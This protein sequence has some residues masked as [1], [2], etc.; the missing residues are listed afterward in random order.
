MS[1]RTDNPYNQDW[2]LLKFNNT[3]SSL[4]VIRLS[5]TGTSTQTDTNTSTQIFGATAVGST[6]TSSTFSNAQIYIPNYTSSNYKTWATESVNE[7]NATGSEAITNMFG[8][9]WSNTAAITRVTLTPYS[10]GTIQQYSTAYLYGI[11]N[12]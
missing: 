2:L 8:G 11:K 3:N 5:G 9:L 4:S 1:A 12:S 7:I 6:A 10:A